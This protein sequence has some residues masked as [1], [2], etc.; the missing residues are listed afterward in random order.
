[1]VL[2]AVQAAPVTRASGAV[3]AE[4][5]VAVVAAASS[6]PVMADVVEE[7]IVWSVVAMPL[8]GT[9]AVNCMLVFV[10]E[11]IVKYES[12]VGSHPLMAGR[13]K[14]PT[15]RRKQPLHFWSAIGR[16]FLRIK[17]LI[18]DVKQSDL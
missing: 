5:D 10:V 18:R 17:M 7:D 13:L 1:M 3:L 16:I 8:V 2:A 4:V 6:Q 11:F 14:T 12:G 9:L 15:H